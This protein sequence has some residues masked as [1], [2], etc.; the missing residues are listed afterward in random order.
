[1]SDQPPAPALPDFDALWDYP[2]PAESERRFRALVPVAEASGDA[3][4]LAQLLSQIARAQ[5]L[6]RRY[7]DA[8]ATLDRAEA[9]LTA[10][11]HLPRVRCLLERGRIRNDQLQGDRGRAV[12]LEAWEIGRRERIDN[13]AVDAAHMLGII[14]PQAE[15]V[16]WHLRALEYARQ[17][18]DPKARRWAATLSNNLGWTYSAAGEHQKALDLFHESRRLRE[19]QGNRDGERIARWSIAKTLRL[20]GRVEEALAMHEAIAGEMQA[21][22]ESDGYGHEEMAE[23]LLALGRADEARPHFAQAYE[24]L[25]KDPWFPPTE[26]DRLERLRRLGA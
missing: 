5:C 17:S 23:C 12:F 26:P 19:E 21:A 24:V 7:G 8:D 20:M 4:Y 13:H 3:S 18:P 11:S 16:E 10:E 14:A 2:N 6:Q 9:L 1:M 22:G 25:S 15:A